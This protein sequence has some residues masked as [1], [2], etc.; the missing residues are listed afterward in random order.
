MS[1]AS[2]AKYQNI[3]AAEL[4][5]WIATNPNRSRQLS[6]IEF[7]QAS[8]GD[9]AAGSLDNMGLPHVTVT[10]LNPSTLLA[11]F[12]WIA[13]P[14]F[15]AALPT[16]RTAM[17]RD[18]ATKLQES[19]DHL[20]GT[21]LAR[22]R[23]R[24]HDWIGLIAG[25]GTIKDTDETNE[26]LDCYGS[27]AALQGA[28]IILVKRQTTEEGED[29]TGGTGLQG[30]VYF[31]TNPINWD[32]RRPVW[33]ADYRARWISETAPTEINLAQWL[34]AIES[35]GWIVQWPEAEGTKESIVG[36]LKST[37]TWTAADSKLRKE[38]L[39]R[40]LGRVK[41]LAAVR[42]AAGGAGAG[43]YDL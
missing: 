14:L 29:V 42:P 28:Q 5:G 16:V 36:E 11:V 2:T 3:A 37:P 18:F 43:A 26:W 7:T 41:T 12:H 24:I 22:K 34:G 35:M 33:I 10:T 8:N 19:T 21:S 9:G 4:F 31:A 30:E 15:A 1:A 25:G 40:R 17:L 20:Q 23:R 6:P 27:L 39:A 13:D 38:V 32:S